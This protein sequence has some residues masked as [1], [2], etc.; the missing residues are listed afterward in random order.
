M[1]AP[2]GPSMATS[3]SPPG[4]AGRTVQCRGM[5][6]ELAQA[7][8]AWADG[9]GGAGVFVVAVLD[10]SVLAL[11]HATDGLIMYLTIQQPAR[12]WDYAAM[13]VA[14][15][16][17][18][19]WPLYLLARRGGDAFID[20][21]LSGARARQALAWYRRSAFAAVAI[22]AF[23]PPPMPL[24][25]FVLLAGATGYPLWRTA[26]ALLVGRGARHAIEATLAAAYR[27]EAV[28]VVE[29][30]R[31]VLAVGLIAAMAVVALGA[32]GWQRRQAAA[33]TS[34]GD[35]RRP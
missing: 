17:A 15:A 6:L 19:S 29:R 12:P 18:G 26:L 21:R 23:L 10:S 22:P 33:A 2:R 7:V 8:R 3:A 35:N 30:Y 31:T 4:D 14:G 32:Y 28:A 34:V 13:G 11:P 27:D 24:K 9:A 25:V 5:L 20:R 1:A 16:L